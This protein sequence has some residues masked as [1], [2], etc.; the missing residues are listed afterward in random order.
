MFYGTFLLLP[1]TIAHNMGLL[2]RF[3][4]YSFLAKMGFFKTD[5]NMEHLARS[6]VEEDKF[7]LAFVII[8]EGAK[9]IL[10]LIISCDC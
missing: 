5:S 10:K 7:A 3:G 4:I 8:S 1:V 6:V 9:L 2:K